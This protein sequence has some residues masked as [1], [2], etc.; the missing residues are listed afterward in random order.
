MLLLLPSMYIASGIRERSAREPLTITGRGRGKKR[1]E[2]VMSVNESESSDGGDIRQRLG[3]R[4]DASN[5][6]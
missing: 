1:K 4:A 5:H 6:G 2:L 3:A